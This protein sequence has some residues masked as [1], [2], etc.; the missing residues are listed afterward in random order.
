MARICI[1]CRDLEADPGEVLCYVCKGAEPVP[2]HVES[3][4]YLLSEAEGIFKRYVR[5]PDRSGP[6]ALALWMAV[7]HAKDAFDVAPYINITSATK[8]SGKSRILEVAEHLVREPLRV[9][10]ASPAYVYRTMAGA[11][12]LLDESDK[13]FAGKDEY[14]A[15]L[16]GAINGGWRRGSGAGR[17]DK[18]GA[19]LTPV[20]FDAFGP[21]ML[22]GIGRR[23]PDTIQDRAIPIYMEPKAFG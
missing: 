23:V 1:E 9:D 10:N 14:S 6:I 11:T 19:G 7:T 13:V 3:I 16:T 18:N 20:K 12:L 8:R 17:V 22:A 21:K 5:F 15:A 4:G 2:P